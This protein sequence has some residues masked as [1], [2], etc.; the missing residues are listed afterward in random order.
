[1]TPVKVVH[2]ASSS[3]VWEVTVSLRIVGVLKNLAGL[4]RRIELGP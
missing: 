4:G 1:M 3:T 2:Y